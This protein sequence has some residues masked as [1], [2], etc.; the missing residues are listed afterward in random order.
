L[1]RLESEIVRDSILAVSGKLNDTIGGAPVTMRYGSD[2]RVAISEKDLPA[3][4][5]QSR[6]SLYLFTRRSYNLNLLSV[7]D[8]PVMDANCPKRNQSAVV[9]QS[10]T[11]L[12]DQFVLEQSRHFAQRVAQ[13]SGDS[14]AGQI[15]T[16][17]RL[18]L[19]RR[20]NGKEAEWALASMRNVV[21]DYRSEG[22]DLNAAREKAL[23]VICHTLLN[24]NE[25]LYVQ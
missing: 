24:T 25:F 8:E 17:F 4:S 7:F 1:R 12:N 3:P 5:A 2:G 19:G 14:A 18:A 6:R 21:D 9:L 11:M 13:V 22:L 23:A 16:A 20:A 10:L 15:E